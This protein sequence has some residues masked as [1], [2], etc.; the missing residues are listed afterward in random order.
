MYGECVPSGWNDLLSIPLMSTAVVYYHTLMLYLY[1]CACV[2][3]FVFVC[4]C[5]RVCVC[6]YMFVCVFLSNLVAAI[7]SIAGG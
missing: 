6:V 7:P 4:V 2:C 5:L 3:V 1:V